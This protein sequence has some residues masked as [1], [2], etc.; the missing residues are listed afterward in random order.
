L[1]GQRHSPSAVGVPISK[2]RPR[3]GSQNSPLPATQSQLA[4]LPRTRRSS[5]SAPAATAAMPP[6]ADFKMRA[7]RW[8]PAKAVCTPGRTIRITTASPRWPAC[9]DCRGASS[10]P[11]AGA[12]SGRVSSLRQPGIG[13]G[14]PLRCRTGLGQR[15]KNCAATQTRSS[16]TRANCAPT[17]QPSCDELRSSAA[18][19]LTVAHGT[20]IAAKPEPSGSTGANHVLRD[21]KWDEDPGSGPTH[22]ERRGNRFLACGCLPPRA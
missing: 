9:E 2:S 13:V 3:R 12:G 5:P 20:Q 6:P 10:R 4:T 19:Q 15:S 21:E 7:I 11:A 22:Q 14:D 8:R 17:R 16:C 1:A 18:A